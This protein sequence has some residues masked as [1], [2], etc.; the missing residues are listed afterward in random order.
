MF[1]NG[2]T[3][4]QMSVSLLIRPAPAESG[5]ADNRIT[6]IERKCLR[7]FRS[8]MFVGGDVLPEI[9]TALN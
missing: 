6:A 4:R 7:S 9:K 5:V 3:R 1:Y 8:I 2:I